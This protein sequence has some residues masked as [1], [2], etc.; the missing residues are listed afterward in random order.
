MTQPLFRPEAVAHHAAGR[1]ERRTEPQLREHGTVRGFRLLLALL[2]LALA[3]SYLV[4]AAETA[5]GEA[6]ANGGRI[7]GV[8]LPAAAAPR[9]RAGQAVTLHV[10]ND[11]ATGRV[12]LVG[13]PFASDGRAV[14]PVTVLLDRP[15]PSGL[16]QAT[17]TLSRPR[18]LELMT[19]RL[20]ALWGGGG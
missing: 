8:T 16:G 7:A 3:A 10:G 4:R 2:V 18:V 6:A 14:V 15:L 9:L 20:R 13:E 5:R 11:R 12:G 19:S 17:V 1:R